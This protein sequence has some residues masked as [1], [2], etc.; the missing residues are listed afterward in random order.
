[1][2]MLKNFQPVATS[3]WETGSV[4]H[5]LRYQ[6]V[7]VPQTGQPQTGQPL[8]EAMLLGISGGAVLGYFSFAYEGYDP[9]VALLTRN[10]FNPLQHLFERLGVVQ[11]VHQTTNEAKAVKN[12]LEALEEG[13]APLV[14]ADMFLMPYN[15]VPNDENM[16][17]MIPVIV[18]GYDTAASQVHIADRASVGL[19]ITPEDLA[20]ARGRVKK[21]KYRLVTLD[22]PDM[23]KLPKAI[24][25]GIR[26][27]ISLYTETPPEGA[28]HNFGFAAFQHWAE[29][30]V[31]N[32]DRSA[33]AKVFPRGR[34]LYAGLITTYHSIEIFGTGGKASRPLYADFLD[35]AALI[36]NKPV[37][38]ESAAH[39]R[40]SGEAWRD[41][42]I[43]L[44][45]DDVPL[46][47]EARQLT[48]QRSELFREQGRAA[49]GEFRRINSRL[50]A[51]K[52]EVSAEFPLNAAGTAALLQNIRAHVLQIH[53][54]E[55]EAVNALEA[56]MT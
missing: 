9:H 5:A 8:S 49:L 42:A 46:L 37:L 31:K 15:P 34:N 48:Q 53:D 24:E 50:A 45:P 43:A 29:L 19:C 12:L 36:L 40:R 1:M 32:K 30:L 33:W 27:S 20:M 17:L 16:W 10:T 56:A 18:Y 52:S 47:A 28:K 54:I 55:L 21:D 25:R 35:E 3:H 22:V 38:E 44:L 4:Y 2:T 23:S 6:G 39:F 41:L 7:T 26:F 51:I 14:W 13:R 11:N